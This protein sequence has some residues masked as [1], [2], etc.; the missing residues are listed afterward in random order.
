MAVLSLAA[1]LENVS[2]Y[3]IVDGNLESDPLQT[4]HKLIVEE[5]IDILG[6]TVMGGPQ[7]ENAVIHSAAVK[8]R[9][10]RLRIVWGGYF[11]TQ[12]YEVCLKADYVDF[13]VRGHGEFVFR[14]FI[15][16]LKE[17][18]DVH[19][20]D[21][22]AFRQDGSSK[23]NPMARIPIPD[24][25][26]DFPYERL[27]MSRYLRKTFMGD[28]TAPHHS[29]YGC[30]FHCNFCAVVNMVNGKWLSQSA[31]RT[32]SVVEG[33]VKNYGADAIEFY[34]NNFFVHEARVLEFAERIEKLNLGWWGEA[35]IDTMMKYSDST[36]SKMKD[37]GLRMAFLGA[38]SGSNETLQRMN[39]GGKAT[40]EKTLEIA[41]K[42]KHFDIIPEMSFVL[43][44]P[45]EPEEDSE[46]TMAF[47]RKVKKVNPATEVILYMYT[48]V[49]LSGTL[50]DEAKAKGFAFPESLE[51]WIGDD[52]KEFSQRRS[53]QVPWVQDPLRKRIHGF[54]Q[55]L[56]AYYPTSTD[57]T[58]TGVKR[59]M[60]RALGSWRYHSGFYQYPI[61]LKVFHKLFGY[62]RPETSSF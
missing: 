13:V 44:N 50:F 53:A 28:R 21:G 46:Q 3:Q 58:I 12:H 15:Q 60:L 17:G 38:E 32:A 34:D 52:W 29:S 25:L 5:N 37:S 56:N 30:P 61:E 57:I 45:P 33:L 19:S 11:P 31:D 59:G 18:R 42:M 1:V 51:A 55:V 8:E 62:R 43:G 10:P 14:D 16:A 23:T 22:L 6:V 54:E 39:K 27:D 35:R 4:L 40:V 48:P 36:W 26:P 7:L 2:D 47:I 24:E 9:H 41:A 49:P 20:L